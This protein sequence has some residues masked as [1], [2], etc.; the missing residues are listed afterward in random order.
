MARLRPAGWEVICDWPEMQRHEPKTLDPRHAEKIC[1]ALINGLMRADILWV[2]L[3]KCKSEGAFWEFG[4]FYGL[5]C[6][7]A[8]GGIIVSGDLKSEEA[9]K[10]NR[11]YPYGMGTKGMLFPEHADVLEYLLKM[12]V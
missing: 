7:E 3:P 9:Q 11:L 2:M 6:N 12:S 5:H 4:F 8:K 10:L 1:Q